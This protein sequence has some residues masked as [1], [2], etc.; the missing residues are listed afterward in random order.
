MF[1]PV[2]FSG[3]PSSVSPHKECLCSK[4]AL[5]CILDALKS[6]FNLE[7]SLFYP[8]KYMGM[9]GILHN[10]LY[11]H[12]FLPYI[13]QLFVL[14]YLSS[15]PFIICSEEGA[16]QHIKH[17][18]LDKALL[19]FLFLIQVYNAGVFLGMKIWTVKYV[20]DLICALSIL[21]PSSPPHIASSPHLP[22]STLIAIKVTT[23]MPFRLNGNDGMMPGAER[24]SSN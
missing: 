16:L 13:S 22:I 11:R 19:A 6:I 8:D 5:P 4:I 20:I 3:N 7:F 12:S 17:L 24:L 21:P 18:Q 10:I 23:Q 1:T 14:N 2:Y 9:A 15:S